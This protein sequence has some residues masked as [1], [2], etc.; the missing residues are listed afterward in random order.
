M[1]VIKRNGEI[2]NYDVSKIESAIAKALTATDEVPVSLLSMKA[3]SV[4]A[5]VEVKIAEAHVDGSDPSVEEIQDYVE[6]MLMQS[7]LQK[8]AKAYILYRQ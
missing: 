2:V 4:A 3:R 6:Q 1:R 8:T 7:G 5:M